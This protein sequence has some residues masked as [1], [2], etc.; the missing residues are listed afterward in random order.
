[1]IE[2]GIT[3]ETSRKGEPGKLTFSVVKDNIIDFQE[4]NHVRLTVDGV[5]LFYGFVFVP[6]G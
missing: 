2:E 1:M 5:N 6:A 4:G 3:W